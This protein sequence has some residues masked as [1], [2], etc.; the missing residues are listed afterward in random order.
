VSNPE[1]ILR[2]WSGVAAAWERHA[3]TI[4]STTGPV[5]EWLVEKLDPQPGQTILE[6]AAGPG[7]TGFLVAQELGDGGRLISSD[8]A[9][10]MTEVA[11]RRAANLGLGNIDFRVLDAQGIDLPDDHVDGIVC[12]F[13]FMLMPEPDAALAECRRVLR[14]GG[15]MVSAT[16][17]SPE[18]NP[19]IMAVG[20]AMIQH[21]HPPAGDPFEP[22]GIFSMSDPERVGAML[23]RAGFGETHVEELEFQHRFPSFDDYWKLQS[24]VSGTLAETIAGLPEPERAAVTETVRESVTPFA[25]DEGLALPAAAVVASAR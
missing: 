2:T 14:D 25:D 17:A 22:G 1:D 10:E 3:D 20:M 6:L 19:W 12:R 7:D 23:Q 16:W 5:A 8:F 4:Q 24:E 15:A 18:R 21:G 9:P 13:G 11:R